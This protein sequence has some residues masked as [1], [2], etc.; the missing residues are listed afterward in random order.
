MKQTYVMLLCLNEIIIHFINII[1]ELIKLF[2]TKLV[3]K[4]FSIYEFFELL[5][6]LF[7]IVHVENNILQ[8]K[9]SKK[10][11]LK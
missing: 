6:I 1:I 8:N 9:I 10:N 2:S 11:R 7:R 3:L 4:I 5:N